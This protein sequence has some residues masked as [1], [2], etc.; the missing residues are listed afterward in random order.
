MLTEIRKTER[1]PIHERLHRLHEA[2]LQR[3]QS[4]QR[5]VIQEAKSLAMSPRGS[6]KGRVRSRGESV[7]ENLY[8]DHQIK[9]Q[10]LKQLREEKAR[11]H[12]SSI[13]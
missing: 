4:A 3:I 1:E 8:L 5:K 10:K 7:F 9:E 2:K 13:E 6:P 12:E 11:N